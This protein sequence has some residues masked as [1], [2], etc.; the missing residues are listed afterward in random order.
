MTTHGHQLTLHV[1]V[2]R[3]AVCRLDASDAM[4]DWALGPG[5]TSITRTREELSVVCAEERVPHGMPRIGG[6]VAIRVEGTLA[7]E[8]VGVLAS[9][10]N[11]LAEVGVPILAIG[12][13]DTDYVL[14]RAE[15]LDRSLDALR[16]AGHN[17]TDQ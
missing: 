14:V 10:T 8:L 7:P 5:F 2:E 15:H 12:T 1:G 3:L 11:P 4:P 9:L 13:H 17:V 16:R 6:L